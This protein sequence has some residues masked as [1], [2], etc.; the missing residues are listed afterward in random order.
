LVDAGEFEARCRFHDASA[1]LD[2]MRRVVSDVPGRRP[3]RGSGLGGEGDM[4]GAGAGPRVPDDEAFEH[5]ARTTRPSADDTETTVR[6]TPVVV[7]C[8]SDGVVT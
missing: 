2:V 8:F 4:L 6:T 1:A 3:T 5:A 7:R